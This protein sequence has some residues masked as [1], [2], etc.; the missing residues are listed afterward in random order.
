MDYRYMLQSRQ[1]SKTCSLK[2]VRYKRPNTLFHLHEIARKGK[3]IEAENR[4]MVAYSRGNE[5]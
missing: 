1:T 4:L 2:K 3:A 5:D